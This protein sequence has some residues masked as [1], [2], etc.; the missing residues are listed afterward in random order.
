MASVPP[1]WKRLSRVPCSVPSVASSYSESAGERW[2]RRLEN[3]CRGSRWGRLLGHG[4]GGDARLIMLV[5]ALAVPATLVSNFPLEAESSMQL[6]LASL[7][8]DPQTTGAQ[9]GEL[10]I[11]HL[12]M[13]S[14]PV[15]YLCNT[16]YSFRILHR[17][18][19]DGQGPGYWSSGMARSC[20]VRQILTPRYAIRRGE[21]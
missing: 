16:L 6:C 14:D 2:Q 8:L 4:H 1:I 17:A 12:S 11:M 10:Y 21:P 7:D 19:G 5:I 3:R 20:A 9:N 18:L 13:Y 15:K